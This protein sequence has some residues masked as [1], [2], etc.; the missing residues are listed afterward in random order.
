[1]TSLEKLLNLPGSTVIGYQLIEG[2]ICLHL[3]LLSQGMNCSHCQRYTEQLHQ[4]TFLLVRDLPTFGQPVYLKVPRRRFYCRRCQRYVTEKL[5]FIGWRRVYTRRYEQHIY[6][7]VI[8]STVEQISREEELSAEEI[9]G[10][11]QQVSKQLKKKDWSQV[12][13]LS[14]DEI[15]KRKGYRN[16]ITL[17]SNVDTGNLLEVID[18]HKQEEIIEV[19]KQQ[20]LEVRMQV[21]EVSVD[22]W[23][24]FAKVIAEVFPKAA[25]VFDRFHVMKL[26]NE[27]LNKLRKQVGVNVKGSRFLLLKNFA[28]LTEIE[29]EQIRPILNLSTS[30]RIAYELK[31]EFREIYE[32]SRTVKSGLNRMKKWLA[33][34][35]VFYPK[36]AQTIRNHLEGI[37]NY[38]ISR[39]TSGVMEG[40]N[41]KAK[42]IMRQGYG[43]ADFD[44]FRERL[45]A[46]FSD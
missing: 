29:R 14:M 42:L 37:C 35:Q 16:F 19:L 15:S 36:A 1:M 38:F 8:H 32:T 28:D 13:R 44:N 25:V 9:Q 12:E 2:Y 39:T 11:F 34:A 31:E 27:A 3:K 4:T 18:S 22:M 20:P 7:R 30:L 10:I 40:I 43:F 41:N 46:S 45:L 5:E 21:R 23:A 17:V 33:Q 26:V 6:Q 24:G